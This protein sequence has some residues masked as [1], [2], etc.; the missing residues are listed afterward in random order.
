MTGITH[1]GPHLGQYP[2]VLPTL[3]DP[4]S[5]V[6]IVTITL[7]ILGQ[8]VFYF[9]VSIAQIF[10]SIGTCA[11]IELVMTFRRSKVI[12]WP[13]SAMLTGNGIALILR[14]PGTEH[15]DWWSM[16]GW[17]VFAGTGAIALASKYLIRRDGRHVFNPS[18]L[19]LVV[20]F[21]ALGEA[22]ADPQVLWWGP[23]SPGL[24]A[25]F[26]V[27]VVGSL[28]ITRRVH[29]GHSA[30]S[31]WAVFAA[32]IG[33]LAA[34]G[35]AITA[36]WHV[37]PISGIDYWWLLVTSPEVLVFLFFMI[38]DPKTAPSGASPSRSTARPSQS[39]AQ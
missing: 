3:T 27:I 37:G 33:V 1:R 23:L 24:V 8:T 16:Q 4:R 18:N 34:S 13:A 21:L 2:L 30:L 14:V 9:N 38:T 6:A 22:R 20:V 29:Q 12:A 7:Q 26:V 28:V 39:W 31:F 10:V 19:A 35:H 32:A 36:S 5:H 17:W 15:G 11:A 25:A